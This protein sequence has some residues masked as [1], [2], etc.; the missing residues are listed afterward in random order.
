M[1]VK[2]AKI[3]FDADEKLTG[4][5][6]TRTLTKVAGYFTIPFSGPSL[7]VE[8]FPIPLILDIVR[9]FCCSRR[10]SDHATV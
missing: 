5:Q 8:F 3:A 2:S 10:R 4:H 7:R 1:W 6:Q 9:L